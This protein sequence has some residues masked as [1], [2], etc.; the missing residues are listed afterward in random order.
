M[1]EKQSRYA[2]PSVSKTVHPLADATTSSLAALKAYSLG[3]KVVSTTGSSAA[4]P[5]YRRAVEID[6][7]F[8][9]AY[10]MLGRM[11]G[12][13][14]NAALS[15]ENTSK[16]WQL[17]NRTS[18]WERFF[19]AATYDMQV[20]GDM[21][22]AQQTCEAWAR[23]YPRDIRPYGFL[24]GAMYPMKGRYDQAIEKLRKMIE[25]DPDFI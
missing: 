22:K 2:L 20:I 14:G 3:W 21:G 24:S 18:D 23:M 11:Y 8:A 13:T 12:D 4:I 16:A 15:T 19:I 7:Q 1:P 17:R 10:A 9:M 5:L 25:Y 6:P